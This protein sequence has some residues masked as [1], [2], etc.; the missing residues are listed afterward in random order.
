MESRP[1]ISIIMAVKDTGPYLAECLDSILLQTYEN[2]ELVAV[3]DH[4]S[5]DS[6]ER[7][8]DYA[9]RDK[10]IRIFQ[11]T[12]QRLNSALK[13]G[14]INCRGTL[15]NRMDSDDRMPLDKLEAML[16]VWMLH[17]KGVVVAGGVEHFVQKGSVGQG[18]K[19]YDQWLNQVVKTSTHYQQIYKECVIP[20]H[21]WLIHKEDFSA[22]GAFD[23]D[24]YPEDYDLCFR[25]YRKGYKII[26]IN[27][28]LH[29]WRDRADRI[30]RTWEEYRDNRYFD[31]KLQY[32]FEIDRDLSRPLVVWGAGRNGK[33]F[34]MALKKY[35]KEVHWVCDND[36][37]IGKAIFDFQIHHF[38]SIKRLNRPQIIVVIAGPSAQ[39][40]IEC[41]FIEWDKKPIEDF[42]FFI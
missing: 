28:I 33:D 36:R 24:V 29:Y 41:H 25:F 22:V 5:D 17:G 8:I 35:E 34:V 21:C 4:S 14:Y 15:I 37:K 30:S 2:W 42:W 32:F 31:L 3:N 26:G 1:L 13:E 18:F 19:R 39:F 6:W 40:E 10:R 20:S 27:K 23:P 12:G 38:S 7:L 16:N 9:Q 11:C